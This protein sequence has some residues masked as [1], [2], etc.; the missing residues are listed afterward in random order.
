VVPQARFRYPLLDGRRLVP[1]I[2]GGLGVS[3]AEFNDRKGVHAEVRGTDLGLAVAIGGGLEYFL[4]QNIALGVE[5]KYLLT[6]GHKLRDERGTQATRVD[7]FLVA[8]GLRVYFGSLSWL[9][10]R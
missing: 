8:V 9:A 4:T 7:A 3:Y 10:S 1:Y 5:T 2:F 6:R